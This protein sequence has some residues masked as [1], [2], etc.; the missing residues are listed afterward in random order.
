MKEEINKAFRENDLATMERLE[1]LY[2]SLKREVL[3]EK[4]RKY[5]RD[6][7]DKPKERERKLKYYYENRESILAKIKAKNHAKKHGG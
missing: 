5:W 7:L 1:T 3:L 6:H 4:Q 2:F